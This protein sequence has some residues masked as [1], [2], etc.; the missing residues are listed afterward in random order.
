MRGKE[1]FLSFSLAF[2]LLFYMGQTVGNHPR[3]I[4][5]LIDRN[6]G[7]NISFVV[8]LL[9]LVIILL[10]GFWRKIYNVRVEGDISERRKCEFREF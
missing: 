2:L 7:A 9:L 4:D 8:S 6:V 5:E 1:I 3:V 10:F